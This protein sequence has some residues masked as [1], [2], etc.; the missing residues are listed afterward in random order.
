MTDVA[1]RVQLLG[2]AHAVAGGT[3]ISF[4]AD[5]R[6]QL[7]VYLAFHRD[8]VSRER[9]AD[10]F[11]S[12][13][14]ETARQNLRRLLQRVQE[15]PWLHGL[16]VERSRVRWPVATDT[17]EFERALQNL[18][19]D[20]ALALYGGSLLN[21]LESYE[22]SEFASWLEIERTRLH[23]RW[24]DLVFARSGELAGA[25]HSERAATLYQTL[26]GQDEFDEEALTAYMTAAAAAGAKRQALTA[27]R[28]F[29]GRLYREMGLEPTSA[30]QQLAQT[31][32]EEALSAQL[33]PAP[34]L[35]EAP[36]SKVA[37]SVPMPSTSFIGR[38]LELAETANLLS[39]PAC[40]L[41]T[42]IGPGGVGKT[43]VALQAANELAHRYAD[44]TYFVALDALSSPDAI[45][46]TIAAALELAL[47][48]QSRPLEQVSQFIGRKQLLLVLDNFE[49]LIEGAPLVSE[50]LG[51]CPHL[52]VV[53]TSRERLN[54]Q[55]EWTL[56]IEGLTVPRG[57]PS[58][59]EAQAYD[60]IALFVERAKR[61]SPSFVLTQK[62]FSGVLRVCHLVNGFPLGIE[63][64]A[65]WVRAMSAQGIAQEIEQNLDFLVTPSR[66]AP[67]RH[68]S[69][70][71]VFEHSW[72]LLSQKVQE[73][74][75]HLSIF[76]GGFTREATSVVAG[77]NI[78]SLAAL[79]DK[80][81]LRFSENRYDLHPLL[82]QYAYEKL[83]AVGW[84][85][86]A[87]AKHGRFFL[88]LA[89]TAK[90]Q[91]VGS[92]RGV[93]LKR[94]EEEYDN[95]RVALGWFQAPADGETGL[96]LVS[97]LWRFWWSRGYLDE[98]KAWITSAL[99]QPAAE[100]KTATRANALYGLGA[101]SLAQANYAAAH[102]HLTQSLG[103][104]RSLDDDGVANVVNALGISAVR[105]GNYG[106]A[107]AYY[108]EGLAIRR[109]MR[110]RDGI[111][112]FL[113][114]LGVVAMDQRDYQGAR[115]LYEEGLLVSRELGNSYLTASFL[116]NLGLTSFWLADY[117]SARKFLEESL[118]ISREAGDLPT[119]SNALSNF[120]LVACEQKDYESAHRFSRE[121][122]LLRREL[123]DRWGIAYSLEVLAR[124]AVAEGEP[125]RAVCLW[126]T[127][128]VVRQAINAPLLGDWRAH[129]ERHIATARAQLDEAAFAA[130]WAEGRMVRVDDAVAYALSGEVN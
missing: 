115:A 27:Y 65:V 41:L 33:A 129:C 40:R 54:L 11:W 28:T 48:G 10:L 73:V 112:G 57:T 44:G 74:P 6:H 70:R 53:T 55:E 61:V 36:L 46:V 124:L 8:W 116:T 84:K 87:H 60:A 86:E 16:E 107:R 75:I 19:L 66:N 25:G 94:L 37:L 76:R 22:D 79:V 69:V 26:L 80:S 105:Q 125:R 21:G 31:L 108:E 5:K 72:A 100:A 102:D 13:A 62:E 58:V 118:P 128:E 23:G 50:L 42:L 113:N 45:D 49:H 114:N 9:L 52:A 123:G 121:N 67:E 32:Q 18:E 1:L 110:D 77:A 12:E 17:A 104:Y 15:L 85:A 88:T 103:I 14:A 63:L 99:S 120:G 71:A 106:A 101:I 43:R 126:G 34:P 81:L 83:E 119:L 29:V 111:A 122:L 130:A 93:W 20:R 92:Q 24:R 35:Q 38:D 90:S 56:P 127:A 117:P 30:T 89:E 2:E 82:Q 91:G 7:L 96:R 47:N 59:E 97:L 51:A 95:F 39:N 109:R 64:A 68:R 4:L 3:R 78:A 98:G